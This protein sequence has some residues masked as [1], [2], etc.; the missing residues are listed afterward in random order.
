MPQANETGEWATVTEREFAP[1]DYELSLDVV[2]Q[3]TSTVRWA[4]PC[5]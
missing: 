3:M 4:L 5:T 2:S 1:A